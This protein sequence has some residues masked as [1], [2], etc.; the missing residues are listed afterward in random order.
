MCFCLAIVP[1]Q[2]DGQPV[3]VKDLQ[4]IIAL[5]IGSWGGGSDLWGSTGDNSKVGGR[6]L[7]CVEESP[8]ITT[9]YFLSVFDR[10]G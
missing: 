4:G 1:L 6:R 7:S 2:G 5:N 10:T 8:F 9:F 3:S